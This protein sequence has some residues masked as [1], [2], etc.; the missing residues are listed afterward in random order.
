MSNHAQSGQRP[1]SGI[2]LVDKPAGATSNRVLQRTKR[3]FGARKA[4]HTGTLDP[5]AT[6]MLPICFGAA[7]KVAGLMLSASKSYRVD[8]LFGVATDTGDATGRTVATHESA[9]PG[10][11]VFAGTVAGFRGSISQV[12]PMYSALK[13]EGRRLYDLARE[14]R[15]VTR[16]ARNVEIHAL[17]IE[18]YEWPRACLRVHCSKGTYIRTLVTDIAAGLG[19]LAHVTA[20]R[21][22]S[23]A[24]YAESQMVSPEALEAAADGGPESLDHWLL[25]ID[26]ALSDMP[27]IVVSEPDAVALGHGRTVEPGTAAAVGRVRVYEREGAFVG[28]GEYLPAGK[29]RPIRIFRS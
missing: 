6:G 12:P 4:G 18:D 23:V 3:L 16:S 10:A 19:T 17:Q 2:V 29:L 25:G 7:T 22:L 1:V 14:G 27:R 9:A 5:M 8:M 13:H 11:E 21:R 15:E 28:V 20:L 26:S 24:P